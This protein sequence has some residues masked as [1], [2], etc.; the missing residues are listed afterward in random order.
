[1][2]ETNKFKRLFTILALLLFTISSHGQTAKQES[3]T[4][5]VI[6]HIPVAEIPAQIEQFTARAKDIEKNIQP[7]TEI[8]KIDSTFLSTKEYL[9]QLKKDFDKIV[10]A[11]LDL[12][13]AENKKREW[14]NYQENLVSMRS[15]I[16]DRN[17]QLQAI[18]EE[19]H[20]NE[21]IWEKTRDYARKQKVASELISSSEEVLSNIKTLKK[22]I[23]TQQDQ[24]FIIYKNI[25]DEI[26][27][28]EEVIASL[29]IQIKELQ[30]MFFIQDSPPI[31]NAIDSTSTIS[32]FKSHFIQTINENARVIN[33]YFL[34][35]LSTIYY[36]VA[37]VFL[38]II[39]FLYLK[40]KMRNAPINAQNRD[41]VEAAIIIQKPVSSALVLGMLFSLFFFKNRPFSFT[42]FYLITYM[43][44]V[45]ILASS[46]IEK[47]RKKLLYFLVGLFVVDIIQS[48]LNI[49]VFGNRILFLIIAAITFYVLLQYYKY[50]KSLT[51]KPEK[52]LGKLTN[53]VVL[54]Y[55]IVIVASV[56][57]NILG[58]VGFSFQL[59]N[60]VI[61]SL[62][63]AIVA[64]VMVI[65]LTSILVISTKESKG[66]PY[67]S[68][69]KYQT[70]LIK[71]IKPIIDFSGFALWLF[72]TLNSFG[73][74]E[75]LLNWAGEVMD[76]TWLIGKDKDVEIS[77]GGIIMFFI[78]LI[79]TFV[80]VR[81]VKVVLADDWIRR[82][83][84]PRGMPEAISMT[85]RYFIT[86]FGIYLA[87]IFAGIN[88][89]N[90]G[91]IAGALGVGIGFGL[92]GI[93]SNFIAGLVLSYERP[94]HVGDTIEV[95]TLMG[96]V[97]EIGVR[98]S[99][100]LTFDG[101]EVIIPNSNLITNDVIN[102]TLSNQQ[103]RLKIL[104]R[105][106]LEAEPKI[107]IKI[108]KEIATNHTNTLHNPEPLVIF[109]GYGESSLDFTL[110][111]W[112]YFNVGFTTK[113]E[114][115]LKIY[116]ALKDAGY[117]VPIPQQRVH[118]TTVENVKK[119]ILPPGE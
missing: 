21:E 73:V 45:T 9:D 94:I 47:E 60:A 54:F 75:Y 40:R 17:K 10:V 33:V 8:K 24:V 27:I 81:M 65:I 83:K 22:K 49:Y 95:N 111:F 98:S 20:I 50:R 44:P 4:V 84:I 58:S 11:D 108:L 3:D 80:L 6:S 51:K 110:Y 117:S 41:E 118:Y 16:S 53:Y 57:G 85:L 106:S 102:W 13:K 39:L 109:E 19:I 87:F 71:R 7:S 72:A 74:Y 69:S 56:F 113:S 91:L 14:L 70:L 28:V 62:M 23:K 52:W 2:K 100:V 46:L 30:S 114:V 92:Q 97:T 86:G 43:V 77:L 29:N 18:F 66:L 34:T 25:T 1:M 26:T 107:V 99:K 61:R 116:N 76:I 63:F 88:L 55:F 112:V 12:R 37:F 38:I 15:K 101:S 78:T 68:I 5:A 59:L 89:N 96:N 105:T 115:A 67:F 90:F 42:E 48:Y 119:E 82:S 79:I 64:V 36:Q 93:V 35:H 31:W 32:F 104:I 103:R